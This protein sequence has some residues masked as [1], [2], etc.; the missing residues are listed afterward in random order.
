MQLS[1]EKRTMKE[2]EKRARKYFD[3][4]KPTH[5]WSHVERVLRMARHIG[6]IENADIEVIEAAALLHDI[7]REEGDRKGECHAKL[8]AKMAKTILE[9]LHFP[10]TKSVLH[11]I[12][13]H[14]FRG[15]NPPETLEAKVLYDAD[16]LDAIGAIGICRAYSYAG[17]N[18]QRLYSNF[19]GK[20]K[21]LTKAIDHSEHTPVVEY[22]VKLS[23]IKAKM[24]THEGKRVAE[25]RDRFM[26]SFYERLR[27]EVVGK[28]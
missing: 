3:H 22:H 13:T 27:D 2:I 19:K 14:R 25:E 26:R 7:G 4:A 15:D 12:T 16:K 8:S 5:D 11:C 6:I 17:E 18:G 24:L 1:D 20:E 23:K 21:Q 10:K 28:L 9:E